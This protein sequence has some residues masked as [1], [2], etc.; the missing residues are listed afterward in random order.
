M[1]FVSLR[2]FL[3]AV[4]LAVAVT[5]GPGAPLQ[6]TTIQVGRSLNSDDSVA[7]HTTAFKPNE[8]IHA[9]V[10]ND[11][12]GQGTVSARWV[13]AGQTVREEMKDRLVQPRG[14]HRVP[15]AAAAGRLPARRVPRRAPG[16]PAARRARGNSGSRSDPDQLPTPNLIL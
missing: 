8:T 3:A 6:V 2:L 12:A 5:C 9:S 14:G 16:R 7:T 1:R 13:Y 11:T 4:A 10:L 15:H